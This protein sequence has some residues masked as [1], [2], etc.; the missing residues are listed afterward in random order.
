[1]NADY[2]KYARAERERRFLLR[3]LPPGLSVTDEHL[4]I[5]DNYITN[6]RL[7]LRKIRVPRTRERM[8]KLTQKFAPVPSDLSRTII[9]NI[10]LSQDEYEVFSVFEGNEIR[11][12][13]YPYE[14]EG[15]HFAI[16]IFLGPLRGLI[17]AESS[18]DTDEEMDNYALPPFAVM[19]VTNDEMFTGASLV[20][21][22]S[23]DLRAALKKRRTTNAQ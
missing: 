23:D 16:D 19:E 12:N 2:G 13:R 11:K 3:E 8:W 4:Q 18:F 10:Y 15:H 5:T 14:H 21:L 17:L 7:R 20:N 6:T 9:T 22:T 1:M